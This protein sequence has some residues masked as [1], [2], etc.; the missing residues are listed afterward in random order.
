MLGVTVAEQ[1]RTFGGEIFLI[2]DHF[3]RLKKSLA[4]VGV[5]EVDLAALHSATHEIVEHNLR[6]IPRGSDLGVTVF[7]TPGL[8]PTYSPNGETGPSVG[9]HSYPLPFSLWAAKYASGQ[10]C[11]PVS[12]PQVSSDCW[13]RHL[14]SRSRMHYYLADREAR[15]IHP[16]ARAILADERGNL[17]E[18]STANVVAIFADEGIVSPPRETILPGISLGFVEQLCS[19]LDIEFVWRPIAMHELA[20]ADELLLT[21]TPYSLL[22][23]SRFAQREFDGRDHF[24]RLIDAWSRHVG[25]DMVE[26]ANRFA[27]E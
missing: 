14:K 5:D 11:E 19:E 24:E 23:V 4:T 27:E 9:I 7:V 16:E 2:D 18:A 15:Q 1:L 8:Y 20:D 10:H 25:L 21:S 13:P 17:N 12:V 22:P 6:L 3:A 26:Q